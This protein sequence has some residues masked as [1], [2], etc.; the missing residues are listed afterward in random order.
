MNESMHAHDLIVNVHFAAKRK[1]V[2][3]FFRFQALLSCLLLLLHDVQAAHTSLFSVIPLCSGR[4]LAAGST[5]Q[6]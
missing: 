5:M 1:F 3:G 2:F 6:D 4:A